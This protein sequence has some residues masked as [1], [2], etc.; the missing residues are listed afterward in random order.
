MQ[1]QISVIV[2]VYKVEAYLPQCL[3][4]IA[5]Q[6]YRDL[7]IIVIDDGSPDNCGTICDEYAARDQ[8]FRVI[9][10]KNAGLSAAWNDGIRAATGEWISF[11][12][13]D[14]W[15]EPDYFEKMISDP[16]TE[17]ADIVQTS[18]F[19]SEDGEGRH[20]RRMYISSYYFENGDGREKLITDTIVR[21]QDKRATA[22]IA[23]V[24][25][26]LYRTSFIREHGLLFDER[27]RA[28]LA[29]DALFNV[30]AFTCALVVSGI[31]YY[32]YHY[33]VTGTS[34][35]FRFDP[36]RTS[37]EEYV[38]QRLEENI[39]KPDASGDLIKAFESYCLR[40]IAR[41]LTVSFFH[42]ENKNS[43]RE[44]KCGI[45]EMKSIPCYKRAI[46]ST[47]NPFNDIK[48]KIFQC[49]LRTPWVWPLRILV[50]AWNRVSM[51]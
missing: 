39:C 50:S 49:A 44:I 36:N 2:P 19:Y 42:P 11:V 7:E 24:W 45:G 8:R 27:I 23:G 43:A 26:K 12:D 15:I 51:R 48:L 13:S 1:P 25:G 33:R 21:P 35:S 46:L 16:N 32:G 22:K 30:C 41:N 5:G 37:A 40:D 38:N 17:K 10:K 29:N 28:G 6:T 34:G 4:S 47:D 18:G 31:T 20:V 14:D 3:D 9:H